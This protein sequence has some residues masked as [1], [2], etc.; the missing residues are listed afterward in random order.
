MSLW[1]KARHFHYKWQGTLRWAETAA[2]GGGWDRTGGGVKWWNCRENVHNATDLW[3]PRSESAGGV[4]ENSLVISSPVSQWK[5]RLKNVEMHLQHH[6]ERLSGQHTRCILPV[7]GSIRMLPLSVF[8][9]FFHGWIYSFLISHFH[10]FFPPTA[11]HPCCTI[12][13]LCEWIKLP[14]IHTANV[15]FWHQ[16]R[17]QWRETARVNSF[18][19]RVYWGR[20]L[21][22]E[23]PAGIKGA[24]RNRYNSYHHLRALLMASPAAVNGSN[25]H[26]HL[27]N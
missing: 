22:W 18:D 16:R 6:A 12:G 11:I 14:R 21:E 25:T 7:F 26:L 1:L 2:V 19:G 17:D 13:E 20:V 8:F 27:G 24:N 23:R 9:F 15:A 10:F 3:S 4:A 5:G